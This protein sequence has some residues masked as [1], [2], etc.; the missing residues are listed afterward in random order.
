MGKVFLGQNEL[1]M[2]IGIQG[3]TSMS[4][5][6]LREALQ[7][8]NLSV[9]GTKSQL[10][11]RLEEAHRR[12]IDLLWFVEEDDILEW[13]D[14][15]IVTLRKKYIFNLLIFFFFLFFSSPT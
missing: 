5:C 11:E 7:A 13:S 8:N 3:L 2:D 1:V 12:A 15:G 14:G 6:Q 4:I 9:N 10:V